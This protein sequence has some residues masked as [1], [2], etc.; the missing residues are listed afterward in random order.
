MK[1]L[2]NLDL[3]R[4]ELQNAVIQ[5]LATAPSN[6]TVG[7]IY[8]DT[9]DNELKIAV[10]GPNSNVVWEVVGK[11]YGISII[12]DEG[13]IKL[14]LAD[15]TG[16]TDDVKFTG[17]GGITVSKVSA[18]EIKIDATGV[19]TPN[20]LTLKFDDGTTEG[21]DKYVFDGSAAK[22]IDIVPGNLISFD[23]DAGEIVI[24]HDDL[25]QVYA[26][27]ADTQTTLADIQ[28]LNSLTVDS[29]GHVSAGKFRKLV[30]GTYLGIAAVDNG[31]ITFSHNDTTRSDGTNT[32]VFPAFGETFT[33]VDE[34]VTNATG[35]VTGVKT[36]TITLPTE[37]QLSL[38]DE[39]TGTWIT[40]VSVSNH[41]VTLSRSNTTTATITVG[42]LVIT[43]SE[44]PQQ[45]GNLTV[46]GN[47]SISGNLTVSG[48]TTTL[49]TETVTIEDNIIEIN[50][51]QTGTPDNSLVSGI[52][53]N[54][55]DEDNFQ[56]VFVE[57]TDDFRLG[58]VGDL[59]P[60]LTRDEVNN[61]ELD[62]LLVWDNEDN[63]AVG[64]KPEELGIARKVATII[65][66]VPNET[67]YINNGYVQ[68]VH[69][70]DTEEITV[71]T[72]DDDT[73]ELVY[74]DVLIHNANTI[75]IF[76]GEIGSLEDLKVVVIG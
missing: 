24:D 3:K 69:N 43:K 38:V 75:R 57:L 23:I 32:G 65:K 12:D 56:F 45:T 10:P 5:K 27:T 42:E 17:A 13:D 67:T 64:K 35:H 54:R 2:N 14:R 71:S 25:P 15:S 72:F 41:Q 62:D 73:K 40:G 26:T 8:F 18:D 60:V 29:A 16:A 21:T 33:L 6:P 48:T 53:V 39:G 51:S 4:N 36:K 49:N 44:D 7:Q 66:D 34:V 74:A 55:G 30:A 9:D 19:A 61:L 68:F 59:Q 31:N 20:A 28:I 76:L 37:T 50:S 47:V 1:F 22:T 52:E 11:E 58:K 70:L 63:R 46:G